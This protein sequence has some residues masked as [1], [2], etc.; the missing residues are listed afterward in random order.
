[1]DFFGAFLGEAFSVLA[2]LIIASGVYK[3]FQISG[4]LRETK[5]LLRDLKR[6]MLPLPAPH[7]THSTSGQ[8]TPE[9]LVRAVHA[10]TYDDSI[11]LEPTVLPPQN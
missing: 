7:E 10:G 5:E 11:P 3:L 8:M 2:F 6:N 9:Q 1:V 4:D